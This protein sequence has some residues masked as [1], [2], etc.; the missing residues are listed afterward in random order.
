MK[1]KI[2]FICIFGPLSLGNIDSLALPSYVLPLNFDLA[3][4]QMK[5][6]RVWLGPVYWE[7]TLLFTLQRFCDRYSFSRLSKTSNSSLCKLM[8]NTLTGIAI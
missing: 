1:C 4:V 3:S 5:C 2:M 8:H 6:K 7:H